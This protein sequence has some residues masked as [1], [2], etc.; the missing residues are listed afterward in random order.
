MLYQVFFSFSGGQLE[1]SSSTDP[2]TK[3]YSM[4][5]V[6]VIISAAWQFVLMLARCEMMPEMLAVWSW[7]HISV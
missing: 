3:E 4:P 5:R 2:Q 6:T 7:V 1:L